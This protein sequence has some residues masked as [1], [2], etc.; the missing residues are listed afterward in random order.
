M[1]TL[2]TIAKDRKYVQRRQ[3]RLSGVFVVNFER[4]SHLSLVFLLL[5]F[6]K[7]KF[8]GKRTFFSAALWQW[9]I[10]LHKYSG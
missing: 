10:D 1:S 2:E 5:T 7:H 3:W 4:I 6:N 9:P 8:A